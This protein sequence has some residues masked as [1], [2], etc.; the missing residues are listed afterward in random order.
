M[1]V[2]LTLGH[3]LSSLPPG[4]EESIRVT[5]TRQ[6][7]PCTEEKLLISAIRGEGTTAM[8]CVL[9]SLQECLK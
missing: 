3:E 4:C 2:G 7:R 8:Q 9:M 5:E 1:I 6:A